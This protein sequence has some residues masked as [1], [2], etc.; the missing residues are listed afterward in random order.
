MRFL[1]QGQIKNLDNS[2]RKSPSPTRV[3]ED[4]FYKNFLYEIGVGLCWRSKYIFVKKC[5]KIRMDT[6]LFM[7]T[8]S[9]I[10]IGS[11]TWFLESSVPHHLMR[12]EIDWLILDSLY[13]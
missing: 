5:P 7:I 10:G 11:L 8:S 4:F 6:L 12:E 1:Y 13:L 3:S 2:N 9:T